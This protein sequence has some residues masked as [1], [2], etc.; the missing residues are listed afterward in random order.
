MLNKDAFGEESR[1]KSEESSSR[2]SRIGI[3]T[4]IPIIEII[5]RNE[6]TQRN[7][8]SLTDLRNKTHYYIGNPAPVWVPDLFF[9]ILAGM[10][11]ACFAAKDEA[12]SAAGLR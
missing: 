7:E 12:A 4:I 2:S 6:R 10:C 5:S 1:V 9:R 8:R 11:E 3:I